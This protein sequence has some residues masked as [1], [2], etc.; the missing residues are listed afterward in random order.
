[1]TSACAT[2]KFTDG[3]EGGFIILD[4]GSQLTQLI[5]RQLREL[6]VF[7]EIHPF[8]T[9][10]HE[11]VQRRPKGFILS[12]G[13]RSVFED[14]A[15]IRSIE[16]LRKIAPILGICYGMQLICHQ[17]GGEIEPT[18]NR[19]YGLNHI[20]WNQSLVSEIPM[21]QKVWMSHGD[22]VNKVPPH[23]ECMALSQN[24]HPTVVKGPQ[25]IGLQFHPE[26]SHTDFGI[27]IFKAFIFDMCKAKATWQPQNIVEQIKENLQRQVPKGE[28]VLCALSGGVDSTV[29]GVLL[30]QSL[31]S[32]PVKCLFVDNGLLRKN[33]FQEVLHIYKQLGLKVKG[34]KAGSLFLKKLQGVTDPEQK[35]KIIGSTFIDVFK[36]HMDS[37]IQWLAQGTLY[38][39]VIE[40]LSP[41]GESVT[42]KSHHNV[43]GLPKDFNLKLIEPLRDLFKDEVRGLGKELGI[44]HKF[45]WRHPF[46]GP[47]LAIRCLGE[48]TEKALHT[49]RECDAIYIEELH[50]QGFYHKIWQAFCVLLPVRT[51]GVQGDARTYEKTLAFR[52]VTSR[53][54]MTVDWFD[55]PLEFMKT[56][57]NR[58][59]NEVK[60]INRVVYDVTTKPPGTIEWE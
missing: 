24:G 54:G 17:F 58:V 59:V 37:S 50:K 29:V 1:M 43:G 57:S 53:D 49:L 30:T 11:L 51:V 32:D 19:E 18:D 46:P 14:H 15:P 12:G 39:D 8:D 23:F 38:P 52:A 48:V 6:H 3:F 25:I 13:P 56:F 5:A 10:L 35:R 22:I 4:F 44:P 16:E 40:S 31:G 2:S 60:G 55:F 47:G 21:H 27:D 9:P 45:L 42:I 34:V 26:V 20:S 7:S 28:K 36:K 33:E 41:R